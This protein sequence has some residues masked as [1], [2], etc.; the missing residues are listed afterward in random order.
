MSS[1]DYEYK[2]RDENNRKAICE[3]ALDN[4]SY[5]GD[6]S[7]NSFSIKKSKL[8]DIINRWKENFS[9]LSEELECW[10]NSDVGDKFA[11]KEILRPLHRGKEIKCVFLK[12]YDKGEDTDTLRCVSMYGDIS[13]KV[14]VIDKLF[15]M[16]R[17]TNEDE[18]K[19]IK[20]MKS[21][22][23]IMAALVMSRRIGLKILW[24]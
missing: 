21:H 17:W 12:I 14:K 3:Q 24:E 4:I 8:E 20:M 11:K 5:N 9:E 18:K 16:M 19:H 23:E 6:F 15:R 2:I 10:K 7:K 1:E 22:P 13:I